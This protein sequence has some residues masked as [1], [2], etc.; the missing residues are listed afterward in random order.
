M[1]AED[2]K[3]TLDLLSNEI[4]KSTF[5]ANFSID[6]SN[7]SFKKMLEDTC[8]S[9]DGRQLMYLI[10]LLY[11]LDLNISHYDD[12]L[13]IIKQIV[14]ED[15]HEEHEQLVDFLAEKINEENIPI[16]YNVLH[17]TYSYNKDEEEDFMVPIWNKCIWALGKTGTP[18]AV[19]CIKEFRNS[20]YEW[21]R[22]TVERQYELYGWK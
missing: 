7:N 19:E 6:L 17:T 10:I 1:M 8:N 16:F 20:P 2:E 11:C 21:V 15:W 3:L 12:Y 13:P 5:Y 14:N 18:K 22:K 4:D 9:K